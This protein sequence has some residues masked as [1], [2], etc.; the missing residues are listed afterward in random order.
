MMFRLKRCKVTPRIDAKHVPTYKWLPLL[1]VSG[2]HEKLFLKIDQSAVFNLLCNI[3]LKKRARSW[4]LWSITFAWFQIAMKFLLLIMVISQAAMFW[5]VRLV[6]SAMM[7]SKFVAIITSNVY[8]SES[9]PQKRQHAIQVSVSI[10]V[11]HLCKGSFIIPITDNIKN[12][13]SQ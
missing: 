2:C 10:S 7:V 8:L 9:G 4:F 13:W 12:T 1:L 11:K 5:A 6:L 3:Y